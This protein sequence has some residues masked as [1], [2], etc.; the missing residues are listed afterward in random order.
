MIVFPRRVRLLGRLVGRARV[1][2]AGWLL[3]P[4]RLPNGLTR[5][6]RFTRNQAYRVRASIDRRSR[7]A[8]A[9]G[10]AL[11]QRADIEEMRALSHQHLD[12]LI[13]EPEAAMIG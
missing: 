7:D 12:H 1:V 8:F 4:D 3:K 6:S 2:G 10:P 11:H 13:A 9:R 5:P